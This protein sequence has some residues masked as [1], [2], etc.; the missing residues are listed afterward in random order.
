MINTKQFLLAVLLSL[1][2]FLTA[3][4][5]DKTEVPVKISPE[6]IIDRIVIKFRDDARV[7]IR[8]GK[9]K[10]LAGVKLT[11]LEESSKSYQVT[12]LFIRSESELDDEFRRISSS[13]LDR[14]RNKNS[15]FKIEI[16]DPWEAEQIVNKYNAMPFVEYC[17]AEPEAEPADDIPPETPDFSALQGYLFSAPEG[18]AADSL[19]KVPGG[20]GAGVHVIDIEGNWNTDHEDFAENIGEL[21]GGSL[22][23]YNDWF[24]HGTA[25]I[26][27]IAADSNDYGITGIAYDAQ[28]D[29]V[30]LGNI[31]IAEAVDIASSYLEPG[32]I[33]LIVI[34]TPGPRYDF[35]PTIDHKGYVPVEYFDANFDA[36]QMAS[37]L[38]IIV[39]A[40]A[41]NGYENLDD[42]IY[43]YRFNRNFRDSRSIIIGAGAPPNGYFGMD[44]SRLDFSNYGSRVDLQGWGRSVFTTGYGDYFDGDGDTNQYYTDEFSG[45]SA[46]APMVA[47]AIT[48]LQGAF[49]A[50]YG[51]YMTAEAVRI[52][53]ETTGTP[54]PNPT[55]PIGPRPNLAFALEYLPSAGLTSNPLVVVDSALY[56]NDA[57]QAFWLVNHNTSSDIS[58]EITIDETLEGNPYYGWLDV[59]PMFGTI[60]AGDSISLS[61]DMYSS[62][63]SDTARTYKG[64]IS[65]DHDEW[66][67]YRVPVYF[68]VECNDSSYETL[69]SD[70][71]RGIEF[72][73][74]DITGIG[75]EFSNSDFHNYTIPVGYLDDGTSDQIQI[76]FTFNFYDALFEHIF[77]GINGALS[78]E[79]DEI[80]YNGYFSEIPLP[81]PGIPSLL[82]P[83]WN[84]LTIAEIGSGHGSIYYYTSQNNDSL[85]IEYFQVGN[86]NDESDSLITFEVI[87]TAE[88]R[89][90][91]QYL[92]V[93]ISDLAQTAL[94]GMSLDDGCQIVRHCDISNPIENIPHDSLRIDFIPLFEPYIKSGDVDA[95][96]GIDI[97][98]VVYLI[99]YL[100]AGGPAPIPIQSGNC[101]CIGEIDIDDVVY[102]ITYLFQGGPVPCGYHP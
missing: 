1:P 73:W 28:I 94:V 54:Q 92:D 36:I 13:G 81:G 15:Y 53:L 7:R 63:V 46:A 33:I 82:I 43:E 74:V 32:D 19:W 10:S 88:N 76:G 4:A 62:F 45:T 60:P 16:S 44:R 49:K 56:G 57:N 2:V 23:T 27:I 48:S 25:T 89:I 61:V 11:G 9:L 83:F 90:T 58:Y 21:L 34:Q 66:T 40:V 30:S 12:P 93:G 35:V 59:S 42:P 47:G 99:Q 65:V 8:D 86:Y 96:G 18:V 95:S 38:G 84:D 67:S 3:V 41:G 75:T 102:L 50:R 26:G 22:N 70:Q 71:T 5:A 85:V 79:S 78:F 37:A 68:F 31:G 87:M 100:F 6:M 72:Q 20:T 51:T 52:L 98:D 55:E 39:V 29:F 77:V 24:N 69:R 101:D 17:Y 80:D 97:D 91:F 14:V 64:R